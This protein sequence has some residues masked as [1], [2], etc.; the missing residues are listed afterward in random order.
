MDIFEG[1]NIVAKKLFQENIPLFSLPQHTHK[2][3]L[4]LS[5]RPAGA[6]E[7]WVVELLS[8]D[9]AENFI[10]NPNPY[11]G[12]FLY[13]EARIFRYEHEAWRPSD[14]IFINEPMQEYPI[15]FL[16]KLIAIQKVRNVFKRA[17]LTGKIKLS[18]LFKSE[19]LPLVGVLW[20]N[21]EQWMY[22]LATGEFKGKIGEI[23]KGD[24]VIGP[25]IVDDQTLTSY[26]L[27]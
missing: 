27:C 8:V 15:D 9:D 6:M 19:L 11:G 20:S 2:H 4:G 1:L 14:S 5:S 7:K 22:L 17:L 3:I 13:R 10:K 25:V 21:H 12:S 24:W 16:K 23:N 18:V 26:F